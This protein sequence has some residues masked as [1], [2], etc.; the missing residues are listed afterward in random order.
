MPLPAS[1][2][3]AILETI[4]GRLALLFLAGAV[5]DHATAR[6]A[7]AQMLAAY[8]PETP[9]ELTLA[10][11]IVSF[12]FQALEALSQAANPDLSMN[13]TLRL[14]GSAVSLSRESHKSQRKLG[15]LQRARRIPAQPLPAEIQ[16]AATAPNPEIDTARVEASP[17]VKPL[18]AKQGGQTWS[19][20][21]QKRMTAKRMA[22]KMKKKQAEHAR[23]TAHLAA[24]AASTQTAARSA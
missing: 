12:S 13:R 18:V 3:Q 5:G 14:R 22:E 16:P 20:A 23:Q 1:I 24:A 6:D 19:Q 9:E 10:A 2:P 4:L 15:Q 7:A 11:E 21:L 17:Q 8:R